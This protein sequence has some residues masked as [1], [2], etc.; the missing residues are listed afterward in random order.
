MIEFI[1]VESVANNDADP[2]VNSAASADTHL[3]HESV[4]EEVPVRKKVPKNA[5]QTVK[6]RSGRNPAATSSTTKASKVKTESPP[7]NKS[8]EEATLAESLPT[9]LSKTE[10]RLLNIEANLMEMSSTLDSIGD[11]FQT[12]LNNVATSSQRVRGV[13]D[14][15]FESISNEEQFEAFNANLERPAYE[16]Q[17]YQWLDSHIIEDRSDRRMLDA[18]DLLFTRKFLTECSWTGIG[19]GT[20]KIA[21]MRMSN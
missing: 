15:K 19:R 6:T 14:L 4:F 5:R 10:Q 9:R 21:F 7:G 17:I 12:L 2:F 13:V 20:E 3:F 18:M 1:K 16:Q 8:N 11:Q